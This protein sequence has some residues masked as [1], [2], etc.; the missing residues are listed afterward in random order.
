MILDVSVIPL[1]RSEA[2]VSLPSEAWLSLTSI[3]AD[4]ESLTM[5]AMEHPNA[6]TVEDVIERTQSTLK[7]YENASQRLD[8]VANKLLRL[9][10]PNLYLIK[11]RLESI[12]DDDEVMGRLEKIKIGCEA[13]PFLNALDVDVSA[14]CTYL[15]NAM[16]PLREAEVDVYAQALD[17]YV[18][19]L[20]AVLSRSKK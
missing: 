4:R 3:P 12:E 9:M 15:Q 14:I 8:P 17:G 2:V 13:V 7:E 6:R 11:D 16:S 5:E 18:G 20:K 19:V 10:G 1:L